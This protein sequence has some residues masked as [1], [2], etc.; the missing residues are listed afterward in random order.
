MPRQYMRIEC[1]SPR[2]ATQRAAQ[3][4]TKAENELAYRIGNEMTF[5]L[6]NDAVR[7]ARNKEK[8]TDGLILHSDQGSQYTS[9]AYFDLMQEYHIRPSMSSPGRPY[10][11]AA[12]ENFFGNAEDRVPVPEKVCLQG[13]GRT[14]R[15]RICAILQFRTD[16]S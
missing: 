5:S 11:N 16:R 14:G 8:V 13:R 15:G 10:D 12:M 4:G 2:G 7:E 6:V 9:Q 1:R 3:R